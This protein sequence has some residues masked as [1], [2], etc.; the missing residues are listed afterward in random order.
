[1]SNNHLN[2]E[3]DSSHQITD[4]V[5]RDGPQNL[6]RRNG[7]QNKFETYSA[8]KN[9]SNA[10]GGN[11]LTAAGGLAIHGSNAKYGGKGSGG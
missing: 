6:I 8:K 11:S 9:T 7:S 1:M 3:R 4:A 10:G 5:A 2:N